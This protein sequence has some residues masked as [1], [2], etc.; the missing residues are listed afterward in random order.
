MPL[1]LWEQ[2]WIKYWMWM[3]D[4][5]P[6]PFLVLFLWPS[7]SVSI[8]SSSPRFNPRTL[9]CRNGQRQPGWSLLVQA[10]VL[11]KGKKIMPF[12][13]DYFFKP[14]CFFSLFSPPHPKLKSVVLLLLLPLLTW[15]SFKMRRLQDLVSCICNFAK[16]QEVPNEV[17]VF[18]FLFFPPTPSFA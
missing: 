3:V 13:K 12:Q 16:A 9:Q 6:G 15:I 11:V 14:F 17:R 4:I 7:A 18:S 8:W 1:G 2:W 5:L 10:T